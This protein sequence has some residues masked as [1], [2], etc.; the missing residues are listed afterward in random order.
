VKQKVWIQ[1]IFI[2][3]FGLARGLT[4]GDLGPGLTLILGSNEA[5]K[6]TTLEFVRSIFFG[7]KKISGSANIYE[8]ADG[9]LRRGRLTIYCPVLGPLRV[10]RVERRGAREGVLTVFDGQGRPVEPSAMA[11]FRGGLDRNV[12]ES[13]FAFDLDAMS[14]LDQRALRGKI[15][16]AALGSLHVNPVAVQTVL[17]ERLG[18]LSR[19]TASDGDSLVV[20]QDQLRT[21]ERQLKALNE[22]PARYSLLKE[23]LDLVN[24]E[25]AGLASD[26][27]AMEARFREVQTILRYEQDWKRLLSLESEL[28]SLEGCREF[29]P[30]GLMRFEQAAERRREAQEGLIELENTL[31]RLRKE[32]RALCPDL[33]FSQ[34]ADRIHSL[35]REALRREKTPSEIDKLDAALCRSRDALDKEIS[36]LG[37][38]W[39]RQKIVAI[40]SSMVLEKEVREFIDSWRLCRDRIGHL[41]ARL[42]EADERY[43]R[44]LSK[45]AA[46]KEE[47]RV[48][49]QRC[50]EFLGPE[51][52]QRL[53]QW[54]AHFTR[55]SDLEERLFEKRGRLEDLIAGRKEIEALLSRFTEESTRVISPV[56]FW[57]LVGLAIAS[58][59][60]MLY[61]AWTAHGPI[62][63]LLFVLGA[64]MTL[65]VPSIGRMKAL[66]EHRRALERDSERTALT[67]RKERLTRETAAVESE[68]RHLLKQLEYLRRQQQQTAFEILGDAN[69]QLSSILDAERRSAA[70]EEP[71][72]SRSILERSLQSELSECMVEDERRSEIRRTCQEAQLEFQRL[73]ET[74]EAVIT[75]S[76]L[77]PGFDPEATLALMLRVRELKASSIRISNEES[78]LCAMKQEWVDFSERVRL[79]GLEMDRAASHGV[80]P[81]DQVELW[82]RSEQAAKEVQTRKE[83]LESMILDHDVRLG[84]LKEKKRHAEDQLHALMEAAKASDEES[85]RSR[86]SVHER[87]K[88]CARDR[89]GLLERIMSYPGMEK[90][91][92]TRAFMEAQNWEDN[93]RLETEL[94]SE[95]ER[96]RDRSEHLADRKG[97]IERE[98]ETIE[99]DESTEKLLSERER[100]RARMNGLARKWVSLKTASILLEEAIRVYETEKQPAVLAKG[101]RIFSTITGNAFRNIMF[102]LGKETVRAERSD[103]TVV[104]EEL[105]SRGTLEQLYLALRLAHLDVYHRQEPLPVLMDDILVNFDLDRGR[106]TAECLAKFSEEIGA[107]VLFFT[108]H[109]GTAALFPEKVN[110]VELQLSSARCG[111]T[112][113]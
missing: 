10:E 77:E 89:V 54:K 37:P 13:L 63:Y 93:R 42:Q 99:A 101:S 60:S 107:Q 68:H 21:V 22:Q 27:S 111:R 65:C 8:S 94:A 95:L 90:E 57:T 4:I 53:Q 40:D 87:F 76:G 6:T 38:G 56:L 7:F 33:V 109:P 82:L 18:R 43:R 32:E 104:G 29:P 66:A 44:L 67:A 52:L 9:A 102:P 26:I 108:C 113:K 83:A 69:A 75:H 98:I 12:Y 112:P 86:A 1:E 91:A 30:D 16:A 49:A 3:S 59:G 31:Q 41:D 84:V 28:A 96:L 103:G 50:T 62:K 2:E 36:S 88:L 74:W 72:R 92:E 80:G 46:D 48:L 51:S 5:G 35:H 11:I 23:E 79:L 97:R 105:L 25:R 45:V 17:N 34:H 24:A 73:K 20:L 100:L 19:R 61:A 15:A 39:D 81:L 58:G 64:A 14:R 106:R 78:A 70:A 71:M 55:A 85:F 47:L 110:R